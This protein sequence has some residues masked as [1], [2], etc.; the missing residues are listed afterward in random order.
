MGMGPIVCGIDTF[1]SITASLCHYSKNGGYC[2]LRHA[3]VKNFPGVDSGSKKVAWK[4]YGM[5]LT[6]LA[7]SYGPR[8]AKDL[9]KEKFAY[10]SAEPHSSLARLY[11]SI[12]FLRRQCSEESVCAS[13]LYRRLGN[14]LTAVAH[15]IAMEE[16]KK[17]DEQE[18][19]PESGGH[20]DQPDSGS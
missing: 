16:A 10:R 13:D 17:I 12:L 19:K 4:L 5:N 1:N 2:V 8:G 6:S 9:I 7:R 18:A 14:V 11:K 20:E 3:I 15:E